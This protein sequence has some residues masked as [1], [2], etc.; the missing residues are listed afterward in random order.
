M[1]LDYIGLGVSAPNYPPLN[2]DT[3]F[4]RVNREIRF[5]RNVAVAA[6]VAFAAAVLSIIFFIQQG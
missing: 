2:N 1:K 6:W 4:H 3:E 5:R